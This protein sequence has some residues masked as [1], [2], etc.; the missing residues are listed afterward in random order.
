MEQEKVLSDE[1]LLNYLYTH[2]HWTGNEAFLHI[3]NR[4]K[5]LMDQNSNQ[6]RYHEWLLRMEKEERLQHQT[7]E[8]MREL[9]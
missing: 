9:L 7:L 2:Y 4:L 6:E 3:H 5:E 8:K 1:N